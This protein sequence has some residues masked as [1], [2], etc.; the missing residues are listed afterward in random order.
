VC[1]N[2]IVCHCSPY[3]FRWSPNPFCCLTDFWCSW[4][5]WCGCQGLVLHFHFFLFCLKWSMWSYSL[6]CWLYLYHL[7]VTW[8]LDFVCSIALDKCPGVRPIGVWEVVHRIVSKAALFVIR[9]D[10]QEA[11]GSHQLCAGQL[12]SFESAIYALWSH[13]TLRESSWL[14]WVMHLM[15]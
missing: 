3:S 2:L 9:S 4:A 12:A 5:L 6:V 14:V 7:C 10:I 15:H 13:F 1:L 8:N 11:A